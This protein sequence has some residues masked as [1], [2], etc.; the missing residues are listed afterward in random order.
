M[1]KQQIVDVTGTLLTPSRQG[2]KCLG[3]G[4]HIG[5]ECCCD[6]CE[7]YLYCFS[8]YKHIFKKNWF[9][10]IFLKK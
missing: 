6:E 4:K 9:K 8:Q 3:N 5:Y 2:R 1:R 7:Y 10:K